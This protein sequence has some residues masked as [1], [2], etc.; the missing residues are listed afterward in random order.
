[1][2][3]ISG[4]IENVTQEFLAKF[5]GTRSNVWTTF[6][7]NVNVVPL[8]LNCVTTHTTQPLVDKVGKNH[9]PQKKHLLDWGN[10]LTRAGNDAQS[11]QLIACHKL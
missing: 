6:Y 11:P 3:V 2:A 4:S 7:G 5:M 8:P 10:L 9:P 1:M